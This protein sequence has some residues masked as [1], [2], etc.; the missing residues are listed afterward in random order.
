M[1]ISC[2]ACLR[3]V[4]DRSQ[5]FR[6]ESVS[7]S[8]DGGGNSSAWSVKRN[9]SRHANA[10]C[11]GKR[12]PSR[13]S[14]TVLYRMDSGVYWC[15]SASG[16]RSAAAS[17]TVT[18][19]PVILEIPALPVTEGNNVT[20]SCRHKVTSSNLTADFYKDGVLIG[21]GAAGRMTIHSVSKSDEGLYRCNTSASRGSAE[22][23]MTVR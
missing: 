17:I 14:I 21:S 19:G 4:P 1:S 23:W 9:T 7:V 11:P 10:A 5:F 22:S 13:C 18:D 2:A 12:T 6:Y 20:L 8:C 16:E 3:M 15:Q